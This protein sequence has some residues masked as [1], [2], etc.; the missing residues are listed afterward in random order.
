MGNSCKVCET[1]LMQNNKSDAPIL[2][3]VSLSK[4]NIANNYNDINMLDL[5]ISSSRFY[6]HSSNKIFRSVDNNCASQRVYKV[7][8]EM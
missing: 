5:K 3:E 7:D 8:V 4:I 1:I 6:S 2:E